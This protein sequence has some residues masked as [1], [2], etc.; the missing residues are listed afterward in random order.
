VEAGLGNRRRTIREKQPI[1]ELQDGGVRFP[2]QIP[3]PDGKSRLD[4]TTLTPLLGGR[5]HPVIE[6]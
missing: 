2:S 3:H 4:R 6:I 1:E 5:V